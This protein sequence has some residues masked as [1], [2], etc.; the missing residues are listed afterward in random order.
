MNRRPTCLARLEGDR[1]S[2]SLLFAICAVGL[3][4]IIGLVYDG[5]RAQAGRSEAYAVAAEAARA[6]ANELDLAYLRITGIARLDAREAQA[7][8]AAWIAATGHEGTASS[9]T[10]E[11]TVTVTV[12]TTTEILGVVGIGTITTSAEATARP[13]TGITTPF[14]GT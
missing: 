1:G 11:V 4:V 8:A 7:A 14:G 5:G 13:R 2:M 9:T 3:V 6:G 10:G 12:D